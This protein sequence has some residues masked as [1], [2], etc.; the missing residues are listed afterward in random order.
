MKLKFSRTIFEK[1]STIKFHEQI[2]SGSR[3]VACLPTD[4]RTDMTKLIIA[5]RKYFKPCYK[6]TCPLFTI[7]CRGN[8]LHADASV[9]PRSLVSIYCIQNLE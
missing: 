1:C 4:G 7:H 8:L 2:S 5:F 6:P 9:L 3:V